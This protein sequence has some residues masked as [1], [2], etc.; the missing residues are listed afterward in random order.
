MAT[1][2]TTATIKQ[3]DR[4]IISAREQTAADVKSGLYYPHFANLAGR[5]LKLYGEEAS[6]LVDRDTMP[7]EV[8]ARHEE[9]ETAERQK[10]LDRLSETARSGLSDKE[11]NFTLNY[12]VLVAVRDLRPDDGK[13]PKAA[14]AA[15]TAAQRAKA[16]AQAVKAVD[17]VTGESTVGEA[18][19]FADA[20]SASGTD[21]NVQRLTEADLA[22]AEEA[23]LRRRQAAK[24]K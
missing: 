2:T 8:R 17:P 11:K 15:P 21:S 12:A 23:E 24:K 13:T 4:V 1:T 20:P 9:G 14:P 6:V 19:L 7:A 22:A 10:Y 5:V 18:D 16:V 3:G